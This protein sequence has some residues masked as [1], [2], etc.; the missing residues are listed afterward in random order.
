MLRATSDGALTHKIDIDVKSL[1]KNCQFV[2]LICVFCV[3]IRARRSDLKSRIRLF[4]RRSGVGLA[5]TA[6][7][8]FLS[9]A[10]HEEVYRVF[11]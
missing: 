4:G 2:T 1:K 10:G 6:R 11:R 7:G 8:R 9:G 3:L 5:R